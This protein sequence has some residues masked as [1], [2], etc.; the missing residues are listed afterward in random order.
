M[1]KTSAKFQS[2]WDEKA[3]IYQWEIIDGYKWEIDFND[4][5]IYLS[6]VQD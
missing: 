2:W 1:G 5:T 6:G 3:R 4:C